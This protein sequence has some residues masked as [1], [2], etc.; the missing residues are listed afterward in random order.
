MGEIIDLSQRRAQ[1]DSELSGQPIEAQH[2]PEDLGAVGMGTMTSSDGREFIFDAQAAIEGG[3]KLLRVSNE[4]RKTES[5][6]DARR[7]LQEHPSKEL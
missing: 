5:A 7:D 3:A 2:Q 4:L 6:E 1:R